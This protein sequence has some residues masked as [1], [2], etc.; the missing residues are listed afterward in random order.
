MATVNQLS[1][2]LKALRKALKE[3]DIAGMRKLS[4]STIRVSA[5]GDGEDFFYVALASYMLSKIIT[6]SHYFRQTGRGEFIDKVLDIIDRA[7][8][9]LEKSRPDIYGRRIRQIIMEMRELEHGE[10]RY[11]HGLEAKAR[12]K[13]ASDLYAEGFSAGRAAE[14]TGAHKRDIIQFSG[15]TLIADRTAQTKKVSER[16]SHVRSIFK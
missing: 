6:K 16:L 12:T 3:R 4:G 10:Q 7:L 15:R 8:V 9:G 1:S 13:L 14:I 5:I 11:V 2:A